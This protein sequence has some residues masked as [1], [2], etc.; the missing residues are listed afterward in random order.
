MGHLIL[1]SNVTCPECGHEEAHQMPEDACQF[2]LE[3]PKCEALLKP[4]P[5]DCCV[6]CS[7][8][9]APCPPVQKGEDCNAGEEQAN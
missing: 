3:C 7:Y 5:G 4:L 8:G 9:T 6:F 2:F 1:I